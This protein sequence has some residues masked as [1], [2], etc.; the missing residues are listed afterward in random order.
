MRLEAV[1]HFRPY[2]AL[3][4]LSV[5][6]ERTKNSM[7]V[8]LPIRPAYILVLAMLLCFSK[9]GHSDP[10]GV[11]TSPLLDDFLEEIQEP[12]RLRT[13]P[14]LPMPEWIAQDIPDRPTGQSM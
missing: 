9:V 5:D 13:T 1:H 8:R 14:D 12:R 4:L 7:G 10:A 2:V 3:A 11:D 6:I